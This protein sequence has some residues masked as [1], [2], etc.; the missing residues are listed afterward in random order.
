MSAFVKQ[1][2]PYL[3][4]GLA[5]FGI[6]FKTYIVRTFG[7]NS[8][9]GLQ[10]NRDSLNFEVRDIH[11]KTSELH[12]LPTDIIFLYFGYIKCKNIC[13]NTMGLLYRLKEKLG[14]RASYVFVSLD[15]KRDTKALSLKYLSGFG[16][17]FYIHVS[18]KEKLLNL[19]R[20]YGVMADIRDGEKDYEIDHTSFLFVLD[21]KRRIRLLYMSEQKDIEKIVKDLNHL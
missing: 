6:F 5:G 11:W 1:A 13:P 18:P 16:D 9:Y 19:T 7:N 2:F 12:K 3:L 4:I 20:S 10:M 21:A 14:N 15:P 17:K 8:L